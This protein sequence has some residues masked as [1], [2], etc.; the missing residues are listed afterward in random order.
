[1]A[2]TPDG[3]R[4]LVLDPEGGELVVFDAAT[5]KVAGRVMIDGAPLGVVAAP[6]GRRAYV[7]LGAKNAVA[8]VD[9]EKLAVLRTAE[10]GKGP[11]GVA[12]ARA[13]GSAAGCNE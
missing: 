9:L 13:A 3:K 1:V 6:D 11:D 7:T 10:T 2:F 4:A 12:W 8:A 5:R